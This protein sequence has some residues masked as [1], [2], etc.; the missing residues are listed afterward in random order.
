MS[1]V[2]RLRVLFV[3]GTMGGGGAERQV[4]EILRRLDRTRFEPL[5]YLAMKQ[6]ELLGQV[7]AD[8]P[9]FAFWDGTPESWPRKLLRWIK[10]TRLVRYWHLAHVLRQQRIDVVYDR[11]YLATLDAAGGC[12][13]RPTPRI[14]CCVV[15]PQ[16]ELELHS[17]WSTSLSWWF[18]R[19]AYRSANLVLANSTGLRQRLVDYFQLAPERVQVLYN[20]LVVSRSA[21]QTAIAN[22]RETTVKLTEE[23]L[24]RSVKSLSGSPST[25]GS[26]K[27]AGSRPFLVITAGRLHPQKGH[28]YLLEAINNLVQHQ[29]HLVHL[30]ILGQGESEIEL[31]DY[32]RQHRLESFVTFAGFVDDPRRWYQQA[33]LFVLSS[34]YEGMPN[35]L[36]EAVQSG[37][38]VLST[39]CPSG[40]AEILDNG[41]CGHL[42]PPGNSA[43]LAAGIADALERT[44]AWRAL[45][46]AA[47]Q[48]I[49]QLFD[50]EIGIGRLEQLIEQVSRRPSS[51]SS[52]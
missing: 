52:R 15:D 41:R 2:P 14:S 46:P 44:D 16:P 7:P 17:R 21:T 31:R 35:A 30:M 6:G 29:G 48:R 4:I 1:P 22:D 47:Q 13:L 23:V 33:D 10:L 28:R 40:P 49:Q 39:D 43:A 42:V 51:V 20:M 32:V 36:I 9:I 45:I 11:T 18:A 3:I 5:L 37:L 27:D 38:P 34:L 12:L 19:Q 26:A 25:S 8:V 50:P 24:P